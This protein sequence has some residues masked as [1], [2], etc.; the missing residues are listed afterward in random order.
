MDFG[1]ALPI[2]ALGP[3]AL[4]GIA[5]LLILTGR[6]VPRATYR[7]A[8]EERDKWR[9]AHAV[10]EHARELQSAQLGEL[11]ENSRTTVAFVRAIPR[12]PAD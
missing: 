10:S 1:S 5:V 8:Q 3:A 4:A 9:Q 6:L 12:G 7:D 2:E 11:L